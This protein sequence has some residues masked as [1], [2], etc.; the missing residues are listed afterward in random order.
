[1][2][3]EKTI[4]K[5]GLYCA[6]VQIAL[7]T[8]SLYDRPKRYIQALFDIIG[9][10]SIRAIAKTSAKKKTCCVKVLNAAWHFYRVAECNNVIEPAKLN[11]RTSP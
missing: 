2:V 9:G 11:S 7:Y 1:M 6:S 4:D 10:K 5:V 3:P 8:A